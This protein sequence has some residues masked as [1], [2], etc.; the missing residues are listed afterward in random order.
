M[1]EVRSGGKSPNGPYQPLIPEKRSVYLRPRTCRYRA[2]GS[3]CEACFVA[4]K[5]DSG[6]TRPIFEVS[7]GQ[8]ENGYGT[9]RI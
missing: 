5:A 8:E 7:T 2:H 4:L 6:A 3:R 1:A 9:F